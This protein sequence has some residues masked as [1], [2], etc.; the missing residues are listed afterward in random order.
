MYGLKAVP[1][2]EKQ[3]FPQPVKPSGALAIYGTAGAVSRALRSIAEFSVLTTDPGWIRWQIGI[4]N[5]GFSR[6]RT[7]LGAAI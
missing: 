1:F 5:R 2:R 3:V 6:P 4:L 7:G